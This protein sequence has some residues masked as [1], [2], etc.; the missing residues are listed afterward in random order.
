MT[1]SVND[2]LM[3]PSQSTTIFG[4]VE[5]SEAVGPLA[6]AGYRNIE[7]SSR[8]LK[9]SEQKQA[10]DDL[11]LRIWS[12][13]G[14]L[15]K[16]GGLGTDAERRKAV[17]DEIRAMEDV[18]VYAPCA[19]IVHYF[20]RN[21]DAAGVANWRD[22]VG[23]LHEQAKSIGFVLCLEMVRGRPEI[24]GKFPCVCKSAEVADFV[25]AFDSDNLGVNI[26]VNHVNA[27]E[28]IPDVAANSAGVIR[29][30][31][32]S[33]NHG[34]KEGTP[35]HLPPGEGIIDWPQALG[36]IYRNGYEGPI[37]M[38]LRAEPTHELLVRTREWAE[39]M[40]RLLRSKIE[41]TTEN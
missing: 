23:Q 24:P 25:R 14:T 21:T 40:A 8:T 18:A 17:D 2:F 34:A 9:R 27:Y 36:A 28:D 26:D 32:V 30:I 41:G 4:R 39:A 38:E 15:D 3:Q 22:T 37:N 12:V 11:G 19:Y 29:S 5:L 16:L 6:R 35:R 13:H 31:H 20:C 7:L 1:D 10:A 33:D